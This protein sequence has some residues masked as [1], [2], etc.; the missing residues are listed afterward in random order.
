MKLI[1]LLKLIDREY[2]PPVMD[3]FGL[4]TIPQS[5]W[6]VTICFMAE[7][8]TWLTCN[9]QNEI[10]VPWYQCEVK[11]ITPGEKDTL[12]IWL[13]NINFIKENF[14]DNFI[15]QRSGLNGEKRSS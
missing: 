3:E 15:Y 9:I 11:S 12:E 8:E 2:F 1:D 4:Y 7:E 6:K 10:L 5:V 14:P 13:D